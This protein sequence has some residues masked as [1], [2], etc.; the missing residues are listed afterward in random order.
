MPGIVL[1]VMMSPASARITRTRNRT[2]RAVL[3]SAAVLATAAV[4]LAPAPATAATDTPKAGVAGA[5]VG[6]VNVGGKPRAEP[7]PVQ[8]GMDIFM[9]DRIA[10]RVESRLQVLLLDETVFTVGPKSEVTIDKFVYD[11]ESGAGEVTAKFTEGFMRYVSGK[12][13]K[14]NP[15]D[16]TV[17]TPASTIGIRGTSLYVSDVPDEPDTYVAGLLGPGPKNT[18]RARRG[19]FTMKNAQGSVTVSRPGF[20]VYVTQGEA[21]GEP[22]RLSRDLLDRLHT[23]LRPRQR[24]RAELPGG[25]EAA[26]PGETD[27]TDVNRVA[28]AGVAQTRAD[29]LAGQELRNAVA[30]TNSDAD[31]AN[32]D[33]NRQ[34]DIVQSLTGDAPA[35]PPRDIGVPFFAQ[36]QWANV[37]NL[38]LHITGPN[39][40]SFGRYH[41]FFPNPEG[42][43]GPSGKP[44]AV[45]DNDS[46]GVGG[47]E[48]ATINALVDGGDTRISVF[49][50][51]N[52]TPGTTILADN[53]E[54]T[55][56]LLKNGSIV[57]GPGGSV[58]IRGTLLDKVSPP[59]GE[60]GNTFVAFEI[61]PDGDVRRVRA[62][63]DVPN[64]GLVD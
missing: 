13:G 24:R 26:Q 45:L 64:A 23:N 20:G 48:V 47:S 16:V 11:P 38:D 51:G 9:Q 21:P 33:A 12:V 7:E 4:S 54:L 14:N 39:P 59:E 30:E 19:G 44:V 17:E 55:V 31:E 50:F 1:M 34:A 43:E 62:L 63:R 18:A 49:N 32:A 56:S 10:T 60:P 2:G 37:P 29:E 57:R 42:P 8:S 27:G 5:V 25:T 61:S 22:T 41:V 58:V 40:E 3:A 53:A 6:E 15:D 28:G 36:A 52:Q 46:T 35:Q